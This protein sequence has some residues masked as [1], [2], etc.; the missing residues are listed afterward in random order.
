M[1]DDLAKQEG[2][3][4][5]SAVTERGPSKYLVCYAVFFA[6]PVLVAAAVQVAVFSPTSG[7][8]R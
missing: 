5:Q 1:T 8:T 2:D 4:I 3:G 6:N 7:Q